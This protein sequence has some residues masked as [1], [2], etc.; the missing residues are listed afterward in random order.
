MCPVCIASTAVIVTYLP[1]ESAVRPI[2]RAIAAPITFVLPPAE[3]HADKH[4]RVRQGHA[5]CL[6]NESEQLGFHTTFHSEDTPGLEDDLSLGMPV[7]CVRA[8]AHGRS[9]AIQSAR[10]AGADSRSIKTHDKQAGQT[11]ARLR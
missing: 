10:R 6:Q 11:K 7:V 4:T 2:A 5:A 3:S 9:L 8:L 1:A